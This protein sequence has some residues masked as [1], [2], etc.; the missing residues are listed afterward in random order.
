MK[1]QGATDAKKAAA[2]DKPENG[3]ATKAKRLKVPHDARYALGN[4][5]TVI[6][7]FPTG[8]VRVRQDQ[9]RSG[10]RD[11]GERVFGSS[12]RE[13]KGRSGQDHQIPFL[14]PEPWPSQGGPESRWAMKS[15]V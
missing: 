3:K 13:P 4:L 11:A 2:N 15:K 5:T 7:R 14:V 1:K 8:H 12:I 6:K 9:R 10:S